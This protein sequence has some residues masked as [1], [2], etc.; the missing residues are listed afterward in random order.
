MKEPY[1][2]GLAIHLDPESKE[3]LSREKKKN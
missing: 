1:M 2:K 3:E